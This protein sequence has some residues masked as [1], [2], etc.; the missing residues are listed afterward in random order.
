M[1]KYANKKKSEYT[2][3]MNTQTTDKLK[4]CYIEKSINVQFNV[5]LLTNTCSPAF[6]FF[7]KKTKDEA[8]HVSQGRKFQNSGVTIGEALFLLAIRSPS[9]L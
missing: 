3:R 8:M 6:L 2:A 7:F 9:E 1:L 5:N 4:N